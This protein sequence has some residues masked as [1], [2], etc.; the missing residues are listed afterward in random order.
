MSSNF[1]ILVVDDSEFMRQ[2]IIM[3]LKHAGYDATAAANGVEALKLAES[4]NFNIVLTAINMP[5][6]DG[7]TLIRE[8]RSLSNY[9]NTP[10]ITITTESSDVKK[11]KCKDVGIT[12]WIMK[13]INHYKLLSVVDKFYTR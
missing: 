7:F 13:P 8:L 3:T 1:T 6:M 5:V 9:K 4:Q 11:E 2:G 10:I 12:E